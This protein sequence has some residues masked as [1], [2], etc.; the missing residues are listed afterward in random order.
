[1]QKGMA[2]EHNSS[3][4]NDCDRHPFPEVGMFWKID[5]PK[6]PAAGKSKTF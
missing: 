4:A 5:L 6:K 3:Y 2:Q 1:V